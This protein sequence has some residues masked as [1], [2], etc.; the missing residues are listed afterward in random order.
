MASGFILLAK[1]LT[2]TEIIQ[3]KEGYK[4]ITS[5]QYPKEKY[6]EQREI[7]TAT[8][9][10][11][12]KNPQ[13]KFNDRDDLVN[14]FKFFTPEVEAAIAF[15]NAGGGSL[16]DAVT[17]TTAFNAG[18]GSSRLLWVGS[19][20]RGQT[21]SGV[22]YNAVSMTELTSNFTI[23]GSSDKVQL[24]YLAAPA[25]GS[26]NVVITAD[27]STLIN[28]GFSSYTGAAQTGIPDAETSNTVSTENTLST[29]VTTVAD[30]SWAMLVA[31]ANSDD[32]ANAGSG[33][34]E[35]G[36]SSGGLDLQ[37][38]DGN[39]LVTPAANTTLVV[40]GI[41]QNYGVIMASFAPFT[42]TV[43]GEEVSNSWGNTIGD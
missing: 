9:T 32:N 36:G 12:T 21:T 2:K 43:A 24:W 35:R 37:M 19:V 42:G 38:F 8:S 41:T 34:T 29:T 15:D 18:S 5:Y 1:H 22:T 13:P 14:V 40:N 25:S 10:H 28:G 6:R 31:R 17:Q 30:N 3:T 11:F 39:A 20:V 4:L 33:T 23:G 7:I 26:N 16:V 27:S